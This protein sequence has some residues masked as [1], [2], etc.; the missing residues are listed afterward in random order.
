M[1]RKEGNTA[2]KMN[3][4]KIAELSG[5][6]AATVSRVLNHAEF[7]RPDTRERVMR[8]IKAYDYIPNESARGLSKSSSNLIA[9]I[10]PDV[11]NSFYQEV[12]SGVARVAE[13]EGYDVL[14]YNTDEHQE[15]EHRILRI[16]KGRNL[17]GI[18]LTPVRGS[19]MLTGELVESFEEQGIPVVLFDRDV[20]GKEFSLVIADNAKSAFEAVSTLI[21]EGHSKIA[22]IGGDT[23]SRPVRERRLGYEMAIRAAGLTIRKEFMASCDQKSEIA[24]QKVK[25]MMEMP[26][27]PTAFFTSNSTMTMGCLR[28]MTERRLVIGRDVS[29]I[30]FDDIEALRAI[31]F[32]LSVVDQHPLDIGEHA[33]RIMAKYLREG[34]TGHE[35]EVISPTMILRGSEKIKSIQ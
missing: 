19:D 31:G 15:K 32:N 3:I 30:A 18:I 9:V 1:Q 35:L 4:S 20:F 5:V 2:S 21:G 11:R 13:K 12:L 34:K 10:C 7:V 23:D 14:L 33:M 26:D 25:K 17:A 29:I 28:Y 16:L 24:Y 8:V 27:P 22:L 6:S